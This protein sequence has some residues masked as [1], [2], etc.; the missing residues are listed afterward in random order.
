M[1]PAGPLSTKPSAILETMTILISL[2]VAAGLAQS[3]A[4]NTVTGDWG[5]QHVRLS[6]PRDGRAEVEFDCG[7]GS[8]DVPLAPGKNGGFSV[9]GRYVAERGGPTLKDVT[10]PSQPARYEGSIAGQRMTL[11]VAIGGGDTLGPFELT[12]GGRARLVKCR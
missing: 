10:V 9:Q 12:R 1:S 11:R 2:L 3:S 4:G 6:I 8:L 7:H 5:G